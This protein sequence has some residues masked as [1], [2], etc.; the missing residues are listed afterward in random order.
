MSKKIFN[1]MLAVALVA[2][3]AVFT[4]CG[5]DDDDD[6]N[7][8]EQKGESKDDEGKQEVKTVTIG[9]ENQALNGQGFWC[10]TTAGKNLGSYPDDWGGTTTTYANTYKEGAAT[11]NTT[12]NLYKS[13]WGESDYWSGYAISQ[14]TE[15]TFSA[16]NLTS[17]QYNNAVG[18]AYE[19]KNFSVV[20]S[21]GE[22][23][24]FDQPRN[25]VELYYTN[26]AYT[27]NSIL[28]GDNYAKKFDEND[29]LTCTVTGFAADTTVVASVD[30]DLASK[31]KYVNEWKKADLSKF[32]GVKFVGFTFKGSDMGDWGLNTPAY[33]CIDA[34][35]YEK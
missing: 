20:F 10:G 2:T 30:L 11:F 22:L 31:G 29:F 7:R 34:L 4:S 32:K 19:G 24:D 17:D 35:K 18:K 9:F 3:P 6:V 26:S 1:W 12:Y 21:Y 25:L 8:E 27:V 33:V 15:T 5:D 23:I 14:R 28:N 16:D 13:E